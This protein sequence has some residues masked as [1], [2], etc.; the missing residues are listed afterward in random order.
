M[1]TDLTCLLCHRVPLYGPELWLSVPSA[2][3]FV[4]RHVVCVHDVSFINSIPPVDDAA[5]DSTA[6]LTLDLS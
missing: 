4:S 2:S 6:S 3:T 5:P 1:N